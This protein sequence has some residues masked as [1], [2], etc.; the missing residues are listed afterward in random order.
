MQTQPSGANGWRPACPTLVLRL[1]TAL[2]R[3]P[4]LFLP[5]PPHLGE[6]GPIASNVAATSGSSVSIGCASL[7]SHSRLNPA[8]LQ[9][10]ITN[11][12]PAGAD[13]LGDETRV[14]GPP[15]LLVLIGRA[16][17]LVELFAN[18][19]V[20]LLASNSDPYMAGLVAIGDRRAGLLETL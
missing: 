9:V 5:L 12:E 18:L 10:W 14:K 7:S 11:V 13:E 15:A 3:E 17:H 1:A 19:E 2:F 6:L 8:R 4:R 16:L 20:D